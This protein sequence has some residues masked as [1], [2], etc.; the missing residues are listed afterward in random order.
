MKHS[1]TGD[2]ELR[3]TGPLASVR[4][5]VFS[6]E[7]KLRQ[8]KKAGLSRLENRFLLYFVALAFTF[9]F[10]RAACEAISVCRRE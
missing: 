5:A 1:L 2:N 7:A 6:A 3:A 9:Y 10:G 8:R 4:F